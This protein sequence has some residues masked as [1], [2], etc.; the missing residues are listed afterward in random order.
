MV[1]GNN[2]NCIVIAKLI[3]ILNSDVVQESKFDVYKL[4]C[5]SSTHSVIIQND[6]FVEVDILKINPD[7]TYN[8]KIK[9]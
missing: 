9:D 1:L 6:R 3:G 8:I 7:L 5:S 4:D 2:M